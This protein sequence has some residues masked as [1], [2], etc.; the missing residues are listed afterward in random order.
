MIWNRDIGELIV[1]C[2]VQIQGDFYISCYTDD[3]EV[4]NAEPLF[5]YSYN[6]LFLNSVYAFS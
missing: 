3:S 1:V 5:F 2:S 4:G 6:T